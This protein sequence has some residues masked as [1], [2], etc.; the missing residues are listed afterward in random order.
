V[1]DEHADMEKGTGCVKI[2][3][4]H[5]FND[6]EVGR[7][8]ALPMINILTF[9]GDIRESAEVYDTKGNE[10]DVYSSDIPAEFQKLER[11]AARKAIVAAVD[12]LGLLEEIK[13]HDLT[14]PYGD[15]G[16]VVIEPMLTDQWYV[17]A[18]VLAK[19]AVEAVENGAF[20]SCRSSTKTCTSPGCAI[21]R[22]GVSPV[23][24]G[25]VTVSRHGTTTKATSTLAAAKTKCVR[26]TT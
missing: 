21:F 23:S 11:F 2:T 25:G 3:P 15:R 24:C 18:D 5:D 8:H 26:K 4:A 17:R 9:D 10:S 6:Y 7:R 14:V 19:P 16:G 1:G 12:A 13:P 22:T 20:S